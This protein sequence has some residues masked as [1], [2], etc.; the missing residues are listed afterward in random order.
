MLPVHQVHVRCFG[1]LKDFLPAR[2]QGRHFSHSIKGY[3]SVK[4]TLEAIGVPHTAIGAIVVN[5][6]KKNFSY[7]LQ[8]EDRIKVYPWAKLPAI[9]KFILDSHLGKLAR[10]L[11]LLGF[12][13]LYQNVF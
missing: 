1:G 5:G 6:R 12:D 11:R 8:P 7:Q 10:S 13:T 2:Q 3:P 9:K 4:D